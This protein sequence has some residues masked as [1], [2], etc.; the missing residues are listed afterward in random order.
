[1][2]LNLAL[3]GEGTTTE[4]KMAVGIMLTGVTMATVT[5]VDVKFV[6]F[7]IAMAAVMG[8]AQQQI[9]IGKIQKRLG[10]SSNQLLLAYTPFVVVMLATC[11]PIDMQL[12]DN[13]KSGFDSYSQW[14]GATPNPNPNP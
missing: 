7:L 3:Y 1:M 5:D 14:Y 11:T 4:T 10:A 2:L 12:P 8:A 13:Q 9:L 6:G